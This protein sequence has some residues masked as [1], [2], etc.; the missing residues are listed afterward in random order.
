MQEKIL[1]A[2][3][4]T[5]LFKKG[6]NNS[7]STILHIPYKDYLQP[8]GI[9]NAEDKKTVSIKLIEDQEGNKKIII[10]RVIKE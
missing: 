3:Q 8:L 5:V 2:K 10:E 9:E 6:G 4:N 1:A 7:K